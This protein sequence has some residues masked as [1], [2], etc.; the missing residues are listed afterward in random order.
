MLQKTTRTKR[1]R[2]ARW[3]LLV[4]ALGLAAALVATA[5]SSKRRIEEASELLI[6]GQADLFRKQLFE[7]HVAQGG[8]RPDP[9]VAQQVLSK[10]YDAG[11]RYVAVY[12]SGAEHVVEVGDAVLREKVTVASARPFELRRI[13]ERAHLTAVAAITDSP[14]PSTGATP[15]EPRSPPARRI[16]VLEFEPLVANRL[17]REASTAFLLSSGIAGVFMLLA[18]A[19]SWVL[20]RREFEEEQ[21]QRE[22]R[23]KLL[24][25]MSAVLAHE[26]RNPL[27]SLKGHAELLSEQ[28][29][30]DS[31]QRRKADRIVVEARRLED[32]SRTLLD[33]IR[34]GSIQRRD[35][36]PGELLRQTVEST[37]PTRIEISD[38][39]APGS[40][41]LDPPRIQQVFRN[42]IDNALEASPDGAKVEVQ[43]TGD[44]NILFLSVRDHGDGIPD[45][46]RE[47]IFEPFRTTRAQGV[48]LGLAVARRIVELHG[49]SISAI[50]HAGG[51]AEFRVRIPR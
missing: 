36:N 44:G 4:V 38:D 1:S 27:T 15:S 11:L 39:T 12:Q 41:A 26:I 33:F 23:L 22:H 35:V 42:L 6:R 3:S 43:L 31:R 34:S 47:H 30:E 37:D 28:L 19:L 8:S 10:N 45:G 18:V 51:G 46:E 49:G 16:L 7:T 20:R 14:A 21:R 5:W 50:N 48:G 40:F 32:L 25:E 9:G 29:P 24:G 13:G 2:W 17:E